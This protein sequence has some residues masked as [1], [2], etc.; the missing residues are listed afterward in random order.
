[1]ATILS[2]QQIQEKLKSNLKTDEID[3]AKLYE[4]RLKFISEPLDKLELADEE[5]WREYLYD[6]ENRLTGEKYNS[7]VDFIGYPLPVVAISEDVVADLNKVWNARNA[8][9]SIQY[10][11]ERAERSANEIFAN[12]KIREFIE[13]VGRSVIRNRPQTIVVIDK[14][15]EGNPF[16]VT[17][18]LDRLISYKLEPNGKEFDWICFHHSEYK[19]EL[20]NEVK[21]IAFY[22]STT[23]RVFEK[24][25][26]SVELVV[27][28]THTLGSCPARFYFDE[29]LNQDEQFKRVNLL[30]PSLAD[31]KA[32]NQ[33]NDYIFYAKH[34]QAFNVVEYAAPACDNNDCDNGYI[35]TPGANGKMFKTKCSDCDKSNKIFRGPATAIRIDPKDMNDENDPSGYFRFIAP[36]IGGLVE[37]MKQ[38][39]ALEQ[40]IKKNITG[41]NDTANRDAMNVTQIRAMLEDLRKPLLRIAGMLNRFDQWLYESTIK[42]TLDVDIFRHADYGTEWYL[43]TE[44]ELIM[45]L[46]EA[47][48][49]GLPEGEIDQ[50][51]IQLI[52]TKYNNNPRTAQKLIIENN[53][54]PAPYNT[55]EE[56]YNKVSNN[57]MTSMDLY[58]KANLNKFIYKF[59]R[60]N[61][62]IV[63]WGK[64]IPFDEKINRIIN[65]FK[66]YAEDEQSE[67]DSGEQLQEQSNP[68]EGEE[69]SGM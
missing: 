16:F 9:F 10:P 19:D 36:E 39:I 3:D 34:Y 67:D 46:Q 52:Q 37:L 13:K 63:D 61:G 47:K 14:D 38:Q 54:N 35:N 23:Y 31:F 68:G 50:I 27:E 42:L 51:Y 17:V 11:N 4:S 12:L 29:R 53:I 65:I 66:Q 48:K 59:E 45:M 55:L 8:N 56:C 57:S 20:G 2:N 33:F 64:E 15:M 6:I 21:R 18:C 43:L 28:N 62:S 49:T 25:G 41:S 32:W 44:N 7:V 40:K 30:Y 5:G 1:M 24:S 58:I 26:N 22:D 60:E 69:A